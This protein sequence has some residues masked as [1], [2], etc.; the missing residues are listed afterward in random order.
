MKLAIVVQRYGEGVIGGA[1]RLARM[2]GEKISQHHQVT[3]LTTCAADHRSWANW[4]PP[5]ESQ[6]N[7]VRVLRWPVKRKRNW[8]RFGRRTQA[9]LESSHSPLREYEWVIEQGPECPELVQFIQDQRDE[10][11]FFLF[12][13]YLYYPTFFGLSS[14]ADKSILI[15]TAHDEPPIYLS[16]FRSLFH[17]P[18]SIVFLTEEEQNF[19]QRLF[20][21]Q[22]IPHKVIGVGLDLYPLSSENEGYLLY[23]GRVE[24]GKGCEEL[25]DFCRQLPIGLKVIGPSQIRVPKHV[26]YLGTVSE[27][28]KDRLFARCRALVNP[29]RNESLS[30]SVLEAWAHGK[31]VIV[32][33]ESPVL[34]AHVEKSEGGYVYSSLGDLRDIVGHLDPRRGE[35]GRS[36]VA[37]NYSWDVVLT[38]YEEMLASLAEK[39]ANEQTSKRSLIRGHWL[40]LR[41]GTW[42]LEPGTLMVMRK[43]G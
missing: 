32:S 10:F 15:P 4:F 11:D 28:V 13:T 43:A 19:V 7:E 36:Y 37:E 30:L 35:A 40:L 39:R 12:L 31:P 27:P 18:R 9:L 42:N 24:K 20:H 38:N 8:R 5:G 17:L 26:D 21:N 29:S 41:P 33:D 2:L 34:R 25:F 1:E 22:Y 14:V 6:L 16:I 23:A 3:V